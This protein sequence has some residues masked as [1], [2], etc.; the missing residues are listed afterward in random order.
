VPNTPTTVAPGSK[1]SVPI[2]DPLPPPS[3]FR[4][5]EQFLLCVAY[6]QAIKTSSLPACTLSSE[7]IL[8]QQEANKVG[9][10]SRRGRTM[11]RHTSRRNRRIW[12]GR[13]SCSV[14]AGHS[15]AVR[16]RRDG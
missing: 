13:R 11:H 3:A 15:A 5:I 16:G 14:G 10:S 1:L 6:V 12:T 7:K 8:R 4:T 9:G 2:V